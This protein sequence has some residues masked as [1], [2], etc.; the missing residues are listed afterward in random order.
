MLLNSKDKSPAQD[1]MTHS[2]LTIGEDDDSQFEDS[3][4]NNKIKKTYER[5]ATQMGV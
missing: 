3:L 4:V 2:F 1:N 5:R